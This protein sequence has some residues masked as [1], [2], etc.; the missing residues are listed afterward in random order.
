MH[1]SSLKTGYGWTSAQRNSRG[2]YVAT[3]W[4]CK[5]I[6][7]CSLLEY[8]IVNYCTIYCFFHFT[9]W[10]HNANFSGWKTNFRTS[11]DYGSIPGELFLHREW[12]INYLKIR[13]NLLLSNDK[14]FETSTLSSM[15]IFISLSFRRPWLFPQTSFGTPDILTFFG[16][17]ITPLQYQASLY[18]VDY[19]STTDNSS[20]RFLS[21]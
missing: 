13:M 8:H 17:E 1:V 9:V 6:E 5:H 19:L 14:I 15:F 16:L 20:K 2:Y 10:R 18:S 11:R 12:R 4:G 21:S 3:T 7:E